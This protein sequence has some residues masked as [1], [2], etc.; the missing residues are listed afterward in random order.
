MWDKNNNVSKIVRAVEMQQL[1]WQHKRWQ[2]INC[3]LIQTEKEEVKKGESKPSALTRSACSTHVCTHNIMMSCCLELACDWLK[4]GT[5]LWS[6]LDNMP[7][8]DLPLPRTIHY[9][10]RSVFDL[11]CAIHDQ[12]D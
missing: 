1:M 11:E 3:C 8:K 4:G 9:Q 5:A 2:E 6:V 7:C 12:I 10:S